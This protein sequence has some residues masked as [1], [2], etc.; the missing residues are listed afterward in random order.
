MGRVK[1]FYWDEINKRAE[2]APPDPDIEQFYRDMELERAKELL[3]AARP[4]RLKEDK[5]EPR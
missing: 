2:E 1:D 4:A 3:R 5:H